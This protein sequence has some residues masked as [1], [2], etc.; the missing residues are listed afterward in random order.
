M[1]LFK[2]ETFLPNDLPKA[3]NFGT[4]EAPDAEQQNQHLG[5]IFVT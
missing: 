1:V 5:R 2:K 4:I 3:L